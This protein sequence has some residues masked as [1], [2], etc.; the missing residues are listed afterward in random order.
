VKR[1]RTPKAKDGE[2]KAQWG[3]ERYNNPDLHYAWGKGIGK[4]DAHLLHNV[5]TSKRQSVD[6]DAPLGSP[7]FLWT[8]YEPSFIEELELRGYDIATLKFSIQKKRPENGQIE[9]K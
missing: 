9:N 3:K 8:K 2:L 6:Y 4:C 7:R 1:W 5:L